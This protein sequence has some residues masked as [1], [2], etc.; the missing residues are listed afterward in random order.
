MPQIRCNA[1]NIL[2][3]KL[4]CLS[5]II[6]FLFSFRETT[7][8]ARRFYYFCVSRSSDAKEGA[9]KQSI[10]LT[11][12]KEVVAEEDYAKNFGCRLEKHCK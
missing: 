4:F 5:L 2:T 7:N 11:N 9:G 1:Q 3:I 6:L 12:V 8:E 10:L